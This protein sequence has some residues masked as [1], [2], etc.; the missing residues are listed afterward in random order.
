MNTRKENE[1]EDEGI[2]NFDSLVEVVNKTFNKIKKLHKNRDE[3]N[4]Y[5]FNH[6]RRNTNPGPEIKAFQR[7]NPDL[8]LSPKR[9]RSQS[10][11]DSSLKKKFTPNEW[12]EIQSL[13][14]LNFFQKNAHQ[15]ARP[16]QNYPSP[17]SLKIKAEP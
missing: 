14:K 5:P 2:F 10:V 12:I 4:E 7:Q 11:C 17:Q 13:G 8:N 16:S 15:P 3:K 6:N 9:A 1:N